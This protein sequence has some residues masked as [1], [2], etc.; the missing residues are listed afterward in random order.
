[1]NLNSDAEGFRLKI[2]VETVLQDLDTRMK[3]MEAE[4][5]AS[6]GSIIMSGHQNQAQYA[7]SYLLCDGRA[8]S[9]TDYADLLSVIGTTWGIGNGGHTFNLPDFRGECGRVSCRDRVCY[10]V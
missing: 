5:A 10:Y 8:V 3:S 4:S 2:G 1:M 9:R 6:I 7:S